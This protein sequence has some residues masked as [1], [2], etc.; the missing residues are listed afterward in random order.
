MGAIDTVSRASLS[1]EMLDE[2]EEWARSDEGRRMV[3]EA[4]ERADRLS[5]Q[6]RKARH[7]KPEDFQ[8]PMTV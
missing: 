1:K 6:Y 5:D 4:E 3:R 2:I 7:I 8:C